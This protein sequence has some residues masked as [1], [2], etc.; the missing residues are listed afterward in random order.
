MIAAV[1]RHSSDPF[2]VP[3]DSV[4]QS[5]RVFFCTGSMQTLHTS[6]TSRFRLQHPSGGGRR[7]ARGGD[8]RG[9]P[10]GR[11]RV[12]KPF[13]L[14]SLS[15]QFYS[16]HDILVALD[17]LDRIRIGF[18]PGSFYCSSSCLVVESEACG[19]GR[20]VSAENAL[21]AFWVV[22]AAP[23]SQARL[24]HENR[25]LDFVHW[26]TEQALQCVVV[27]IPLLL[28]FPEDFGGD[29]VSGPLSLWCTRELR[30]LEGLHEARRGAGFLCQLAGADVKRPLGIFSNLPDLQQVLRV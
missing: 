30:D 8:C 9:I 13:W 22:H 19:K 17:L 29:A 18:F 27:R 20:S 2:R 6:D 21:A 26:F 7:G 14:H 10:R 1:R 4:W 12:R 23:E 28:V 15:L 11:Q 16:A 25:S 5:G 3:E 24:Q